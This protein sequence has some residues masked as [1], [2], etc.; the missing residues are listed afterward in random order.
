MRFATVLITVLLVWALP[1]AA[2]QAG[3]PDS[4][5]SAGISAAAKP[6]LKKALKKCRT[7][8]KA[9]RRRACV[10]GSA[11][12]SRTSRRSMPVEPKPGKTWRVDVST[13]KPTTTW[14]S[15]DYF[16]PDYLEIK[17][18]RHDRM[19]LERHESESPQRKPPE[20]P[21]RTST[22]STTRLRTHLHETTAGPAQLD[23]PGTWVF[24]CSLHH[25]MRLAVKVTKVR[26]HHEF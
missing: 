12:S 14:G 11:R 23:K 26:Q 16:S 6:G 24:A 25:L 2:A 10:R 3:A 18:R 7:I 20:R 13:M 17:V 15:T 5:S 1:S 4:G 19:G 9:D 22:G 8:R 21:G